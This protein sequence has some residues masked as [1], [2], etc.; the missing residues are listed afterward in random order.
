MAALALLRSADA[1]ELL[2]A[3]ATLAGRAP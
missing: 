2:A 1:G 3:R